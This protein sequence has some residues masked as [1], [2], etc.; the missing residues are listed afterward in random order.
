MLEVRSSSE[1]S[2]S[3]WM[4]RSWI[5]S[6]CDHWGSWLTGAKRNSTS[7]AR[8]S[9]TTDS[10]TYRRP[11]PSAPRRIDT[12]KHSPYSDGDDH[13][14]EKHNADA[15][16]Q[17]ALARAGTVGSRADSGR[18]GVSRLAASAIALAARGRPSGSASAVRHCDDQHEPQR[19]LYRAA[20]GGS[21]RHHR[22]PGWARGHVRAR[23]ESYRRVGWHQDLR[24]NE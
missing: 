14:K 8:P 15:P 12:A 6:I 17:N 2:R 11:F 22:E 19:R 4:S 3:R 1:Q 7:A 9:N 5:R 18:R 10:R 23:S 20:R 21:Q 16:L 24:S 13:G